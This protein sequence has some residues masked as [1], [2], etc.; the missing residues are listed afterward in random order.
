MK[1]L[2]LTI[3]AF[4]LYGCAMPSTTPSSLFV[5]PEG[6]LARCAAQGWGY[7]GTP[8]AQ[9][10]YDKCVNDM[11]YSGALPVS[12]VGGIG[13][14][15]S[16]ETSTVKILKIVPD[17]PAEAA[18]IKAGSSI[19]KINDQTVTNWNDTRRLLFGRAGTDL[20][21]TIFDGVTEKTIL[22]TR[23]RIFENVANEAS[24]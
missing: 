9:N 10:I 14:V 8:M 11:K 19:V 17:S 3:I 5:T 18:G 16:S 6:K 2:S 23:G 24:N 1:K 21:V 4:A 15:P 7:V 12:V 20:S 13:V 22:M